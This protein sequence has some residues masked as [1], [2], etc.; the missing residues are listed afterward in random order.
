MKAYAQALRQFQSG[1]FQEAETACR[2]IVARD[3]ADAPAL[4]LLGMLAHRA[5]RNDEAV[6]W[7]RRAVGLDPATADYHYNLGVALQV[8]GRLDEAITAY[9][10]VLRA[11]PGR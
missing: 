1:Q 9:A 11:Q 8:L 5:G 6:D 2:A 7:L 3:P 4:N 10:H